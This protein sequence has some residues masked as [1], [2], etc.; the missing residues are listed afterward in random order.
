MRELKLVAKRNPQIAQKSHPLRVRELKHNT[1]QRIKNILESHP[2]R[3][4]E[5]KLGKES[6]DVSKIVAP[7]TGAWIE[8]INGD[9]KTAISKV[10]PFTGAWIETN[11]R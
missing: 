8:T 2:L 9:L 11:N 7:F 3:V 1:N 5:L 4:R 6:L 10:A